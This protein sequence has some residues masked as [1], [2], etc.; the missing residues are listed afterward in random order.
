MIEAIQRSAVDGALRNLSD[1]LVK[2]LERLKGGINS[3]WGQLEEARKTARKNCNALI[4][5]A[6][7]NRKKKFTAAEADYNR[8]ARGPEGASYE[9]YQQERD[10]INDECNVEKEHAA[11]LFSN[12]CEAAE[13]KFRTRTAE[14]IELFGKGINTSVDNFKSAHP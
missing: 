4:E 1:G 11:E 6:E 12:E 2:N 9:V 14:Y 3:A 8:E 10:R 13:N 7:R 5:T